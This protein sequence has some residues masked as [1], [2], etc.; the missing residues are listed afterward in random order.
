[1]RFKMKA[2][3]CSLAATVA[4][5]S[6]GM[7]QFECRDVFDV[8]PQARPTSAPSKPSFFSRLLRLPGRLQEG[9]LISRSNEAPL[10]DQPVLQEERLR[11]FNGLA[12]SILKHDTLR[13]GLAK[14]LLSHMARKAERR[15]SLS[16]L[17][18]RQQLE[19]FEELSYFQEV[20]GEAF[21]S[22]FDA[23][24]AIDRAFNAA[25]YWGTSPRQTLEA[26]YQREGKILKDLEI[27]G[28]EK[29]ASKKEALFG[30]ALRAARD[31]SFLLAIE[32]GNET[33]R[34][35]EAK[36][37]PDEYSYGI[38]RR[39]E[40][41]LSRFW[42]LEAEERSI[43]SRILNAKR[44]ALE[45]AYSYDH[46]RDLG[47]IRYSEKIAGGFINKTVREF[48]AKG[49]FRDGVWWGKFN[50]FQS[51]DAKITGDTSRSPLKRLY[52]PNSSRMI[53]W[54]KENKK[55]GGRMTPDLGRIRAAENFQDGVSK[56][57]EILANARAG[58]AP[59][60]YFFINVEG[61]LV[62][63][64]KFQG[65]RIEKACGR[66]HCESPGG[67][68]AFTPHM[69]KVRE[70]FKRVGYDGDVVIDKLI[71]SAR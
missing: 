50:D 64:R 53:S 4:Y 30:E 45:Q 17:S 54:P 7:A 47:E 71:R 39:L 43:I 58:E 63:A 41:T 38:A 28:L 70:D 31:G 20:L 19:L 65:E 18:A 40:K 59:K 69:L 24:A 22:T 12:F 48:V 35:D 42:L 13:F 46:F 68:M 60:G 23:Q 11:R 52:G 56:S 62:P 66:C 9:L 67:R 29:F 26:Y 61:E 32:N 34:Y 49:R 27:E 57:V 3:Y 8:R 33:I 37:I 44:T 1:M 5:A 6:T 25:V 51:R 14:N 36:G 21:G 10:E 55:D 16:G 2:F 15:F